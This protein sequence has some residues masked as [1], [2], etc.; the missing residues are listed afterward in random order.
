[1][2]LTS[3]E[4]RNRISGQGK[5]GH[6]RQALGLV[7]GPEFREM[8]E[9]QIESSA[10]ITECAANHL[11]VVGS[12]PHAETEDHPPFG[13]LMDRGGLF[14]EHKGIASRRQD[15]IR[16][17]GHTLGRSCY[18]GEDCEGFIDRTG[19]PIQHRDRVK[20]SCLGPGCPRNEVGGHGP[21]DGVRQADPDIYAW[22]EYDRLKLLVGEWRIRPRRQAH[23][24]RAG[25][26]R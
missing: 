10:P 6:L 15:H 4:H 23:R 21:F 24:I 9:H 14:R 25:D 3:D 1:M 5:R 17:E 13:Y 2:V 18:R 22:P 19:Q 7:T 12:P 20:P 8:F 16:D 11:E 26:G